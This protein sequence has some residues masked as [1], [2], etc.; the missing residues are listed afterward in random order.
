[1]SR[2]WQDGRIKL[3][4]KALTSANYFELGTFTDTAYDFALFTDFY[5]FLPV[6]KS[7]KLSKSKTYYFSIASKHPN[8]KRPNIN[9]LKFKNSNTGAFHSQCLKYQRQKA[10][11]S[12]HPLF[13]DQRASCGDLNVHKFIN[14]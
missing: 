6:L 5:R 10:P 14:E 13:A 11:K 1:L 3:A 12:N 4:E 2:R 8:P 7:P 9:N